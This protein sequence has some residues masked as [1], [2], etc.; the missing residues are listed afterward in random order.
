MTIRLWLRTQTVLAVGTLVLALVASP[1]VA[2]ETAKPSFFNS[3]ETES[4][5]LAPFKKWNEALVRYSKEGAAK[6]GAACDPKKFT[7][8]A[9]QDWVKFLDGLKGADKMTQLKELNKYINQATYITDDTNWGQEDYWAT[10]GEFMAKFG[11][12]EDYAIAKFMALK[13]MGYNGDDLRVVAVKDMNLK[14]G[15]AILAAFL[16]GKVYILDNQVKIVVEAEKI[17]HYVPVFSINEKRW[18]RHRV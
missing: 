16:D 8:C 7:T 14:V 17:R 11:D 12:C 3:Q 18:W 15:H 9:F 4:D 2:A 13:L 1:A 6:Q 5:N 10:P